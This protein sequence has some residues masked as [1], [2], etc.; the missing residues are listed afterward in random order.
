MF[1]DN[2]SGFIS[3]VNSLGARRIP[4]FFMIDFD[5]KRPVVKRIDEINPDLIKYTVNGISNCGEERELPRKY[6]FNKSPIGF[7][8]YEDAFRKVMNHIRAGNSYLVN[9]TFATEIKTDLSMEDLYFGSRGKYKLLYENKFVVFSPETFVKIKDGMIYSYPMKG[10]I[11][12]DRENAAEILL[13]DEKET[14]EHYT[15]VDLIRNDLSI[16]A[17]DV[18]VDKFRYIELIKTNRRNLYQTSSAISGRLPE[19]FRSELGDI[20][21]KLLP[22]GSISG[23]PKK[24]TVEIIKEA[25]TYSRDYYTGIFGIFDGQNLDSAVMIRF[26]ENQNGK[27]FFKSGGGITYLSRPEE[28]YQELLDKIYVPTGRID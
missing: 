20:I 1:D 6:I 8:V 3:E 17:K 24:K 7:D 18:K 4:F 12:A 27:M 5:L 19:N 11:D 25:E 9:L 28:E 15:I 23:A 14:A 16:V 13:N 10:T 26:I 21:I 22:A 2:I